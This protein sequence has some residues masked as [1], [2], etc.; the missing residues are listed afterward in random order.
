VISRRRFLKRTLAATVGAS[1]GAGL[2]TWRVEPHWV[3]FVHRSL[4]VAGLPPD[5][6][7]RILVQ[8]SD[9]HVGPHV[10]DAFL[11]RSLDRTASLEPDLVVFTGDFITHRTG[12]EIARLERVLERFPRGRKGT[13]AILGNHDYGPDWSHPEVAKQVAE[14]ATR[15]GITVLRN[16]T[17]TFGGLQI[18]G[19]DELWAGAFAPR[20]AFGQADPATATIALS[21]NH[22]TVD[23]EGWERYQGWVLAG[24]THGGQCKPPFLPPPL[25]P[26]RNRRYT[27]GEFALAGRRRLYINRGLGH[28][29]RVRFNVRP[30]VTVFHLAQE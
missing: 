13:A 22:D 7:G 25:L 9:L 5:L 20:E 28:L 12:A 29:L 21:H 15:S 3:E 17:A 23:L 10:D 8:V 4:P 19:L 27:A 30:E 24:H 1:I 16:A 26:V 14:V 2:Y 11:V 6:R 18:V